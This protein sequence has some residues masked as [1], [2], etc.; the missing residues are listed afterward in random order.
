[1]FNEKT[2]PQT[3]EANERNWFVLIVK[4]DDTDTGPVEVRINFL[5]VIGQDD[6]ALACYDD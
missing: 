2:C 1:M 3:L 6:I 5:Q 4:A